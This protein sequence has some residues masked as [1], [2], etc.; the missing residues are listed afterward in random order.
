MYKL[1]KVLGAGGFGL[2]M[3]ATR[4]KDDLP[5]SAINFIRTKY[6]ACPQGL[7]C[8]FKMA[9]WAW[10]PLKTLPKYYNNHAQYFVT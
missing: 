3:S 6:Q 2:V 7:I 5:V 1:G 10:K 9:E 4:K 8:A